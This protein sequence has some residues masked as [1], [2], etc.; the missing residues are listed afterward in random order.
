MPLDPSRRR[1]LYEL[2]TDVPVPADEERDDKQDV[3]LL[4]IIAAAIAAGF[5]IYAMS[6]DTVV[7]DAPLSSPAS[8]PLARDAETPQE[9]P[10]PILPDNRP[11]E[12][13]VPPKSALP[14][15]Q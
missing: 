11:L 8:K 3:K 6:A 7:S 12:T 2:N 15:E 4:A 14:S 13:L 9:R 5:L 1:V 10:R